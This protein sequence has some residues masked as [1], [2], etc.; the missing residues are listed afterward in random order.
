MQA[1]AGVEQRGS[2]E[3]SAVSYAMPKVPTGAEPFQAPTKVTL[4]S[5]RA[6]CQQSV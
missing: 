3:E 6:N 4:H 1:V 5:S 2:G